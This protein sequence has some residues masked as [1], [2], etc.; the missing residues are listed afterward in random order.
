[1]SKHTKHVPFYTTL[2]CKKI[3]RATGGVKVICPL[4]MGGFNFFRWLNLLW[5]RFRQ[6]MIRIVASR[7][8]FEPV[9]T[10]GSCKN[11][12]L[13]YYDSTTIENVTHSTNSNKKLSIENWMPIHNMLNTSFPRI[14]SLSNKTGGVLSK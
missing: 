2:V 10:L 7:E 9:N 5:C 8:L 13:V 3:A 1:M 14:L 12:I 6:L 11:P 4:S